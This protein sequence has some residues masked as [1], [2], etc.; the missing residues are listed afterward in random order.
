MNFGAEGFT[1]WLLGRK[2]S[3][4]ELNSRTVQRMGE[5]SVRVFVSFVIWM[6]ASRERI[7]Q[8]ML[9]LQKQKWNL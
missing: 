7:E 8:N 2:R 4:V 6:W 1:E 3:S 9:H 5:A